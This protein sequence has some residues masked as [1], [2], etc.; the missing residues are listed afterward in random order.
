MIFLFQITVCTLLFYGVY[1]F[2]YQD[3]SHHVFNRF[4]LLSSLVLA[5]MIPLLYLP[6]FPEYIELQ[7]VPLIPTIEAA[8]ESN[9]LW[10]TWQNLLISIYCLGVLIHLAILGVQ[11]Y[12]L[13]YL[14]QSGKQEKDDGF[15]RVYSPS[16][17]PLSSFFSY[18]IIPLNKKDKLT[19]YEL[20]HEK[21]HIE[22]G[23]TWDIL[24]L[25]CLRIVFWFNPILLLYKKRLVEVHEY[26]ADQNTIRQLGKS[27]YENFLIQQVQIK[28]QQN[29]LHHFYSLFKKRI[30]M[31]NSNA[32]TSAWHYLM[33]LPVVFTAL[34]LFSFETY[35]VYP[36]TNG[37]GMV[38]DTIPD[39]PVE[40]IDTVIVFDPETRTETVHIVR[41]TGDAPPVGS[42][43]PIKASPNKTGVDTVIVFDAEDYSE[44]VIIINHDTGKVDTIQ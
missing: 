38:Q 26:L 17:T 42:V 8:T 15:V 36:E 33:V 21:S 9:T 5:V 11:L 7:P 28:T 25:E 41:R 3:K 12:R 31:M 23:H 14:I 35:P 1:Y 39:A 10:F 16:N 37:D 22:Q 6:V 32:R 19:A 34:F 44:T 24:F 27:G 43:Q 4:Y 29:L 18:L 13:F 2:F 20:K 40:M 30:I